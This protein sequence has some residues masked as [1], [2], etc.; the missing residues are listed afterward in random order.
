MSQKGSSWITGN[1]PVARADS[2]LVGSWIKEAGVR[3]DIVE[4][5]LESFAVVPGSVINL[6]DGRLRMYYQ[7]SEGIDVRIF[8]A[9]SS[10]G[11][12]TW[13]REGLRLDVFGAQEAEVSSPCVVQ[14]NSNLYRM[15]Y[16]DSKILSEYSA[17]NPP[18]A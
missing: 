18:M 13:T 16:Q 17:P 1:I 2:S 14:I 12:L 11:G 15:Y 4:G 3:L 7:A 8:S 10:D 6:P 9:V 5:S